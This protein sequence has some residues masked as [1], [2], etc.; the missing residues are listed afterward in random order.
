MTND[1]LEGMFH[2]HKLMTSAGAIKA[3]SLINAHIS[4]IT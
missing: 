2:G 3:K 1:K 4:W